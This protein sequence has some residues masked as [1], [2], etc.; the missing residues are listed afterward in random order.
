VLTP[1][2]RCQQITADWKKARRPTRK[3]HARDRAEGQASL[4]QVADALHRGRVSWPDGFRLLTADRVKKGFTVVQTVLGFPPD[5]AP[6][7]GQDANEGGSPWEKDFER[8]NPRYFDEVDLRIEW[9]VRSGIV[10]CILGGW[11]YNLLFMGEERMLRHWK[12]LVARYGAYPVVWCLAGETAMP[13]YRSKD[14]SGDSQRQKDAWTRVARFVRESD[15]F[16]RPVSTHPRQRSWED[17]EDPS[18]LDFHMLQVGHCAPYSL[19]RCPTYLEEARSKFPN[20][21]VVMAE[22]PYEGHMGVNGPDVVRYAFWASLLSGAAGFTYGAAGIFQANDRRRPAGKTPAGGAYDGVFWD[23]AI[24]F[25]GS[26]HVGKAKSLLVGLP[27]RRFKPHPEWIQVEAT[28]WHEHYRPP[29]R[30]FAAGIP[31]D[32]RVAYIPARYYQWNGPKVQALEPGVPYRAWY[33]DTATGELV[34]LGDVRPDKGGCW[35]APNLPFLHDWVF[36][37]KRI[38]G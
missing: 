12:Y 10:P 19:E 33:C 23:E 35:Q 6:F 2:E 9:L 7:S 15:T 30:A 38:A 3:A 13:F 18:L 28:V 34:D 37:M 26:C 24:H 22:P 16:K 8:I 11:G 36:V 29:Y 27:F 14:R 17:V 4:L 31:G 32:C 20:V 1:P 5:T 25:V 21:P